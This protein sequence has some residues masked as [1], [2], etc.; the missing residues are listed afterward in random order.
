MRNLVLLAAMGLPVLAA[1]LGA[2]AQTFVPFVIP[3]TQNPGSLIAF[4]SK[5]IAVDS[6]RLVA[7]DGHFFAGGERVRIWG[8]NL[9]FAANFPAHADA[10]RLA[11]RL[12]A[13]GI[14]SVRH[15]HMDGTVFPGGVWDPKDERKLSAEA[16][17]RLDYLMDQLARH[18][19]YSNLNLH[20]S[21]A[22]ARVLKLPDTASIDSFDKMVDLFTPELIDAQKQYARDMLTHVNPYRKSA[23][24]P[25]GVRRADDPA[26]AFVEINNEDSLFM[27]GW[28][29][30]LR[31]LPD[32]YGRLLQ[33]RYNEWLAKRY[34]ADANL[35]KAWSAG[36][37]P[38]GENLLAGASALSEKD[39][40][41]TWRLELH[42][43]CKGSAAPSPGDA[44]AVRIEIAQTD[45]VSWH[46]QF[47]QFGVAL[48]AGQYYTL[49]FRA[50]ADKP[51]EMSLGVGQHEGPW[52]NLG[53]SQNVKLA[54]EWKSFRI[55]FV[56]K[57][58]EKNARVG[59]SLGA[60]A[61]PVELADV[62]LRPGGKEGLAKGESL[63]RV[64]GV[65]PARGEGILPS[66]VVSSSSSSSAATASPASLKGKG[67]REETEARG[68][69]AR[70]TRGQALGAPNGDVRDTPV[71][72]FGPG[73]TDARTIDR[74]RFLA[75]TEKAYFDSMREYVK[76]DLGCQAA[77]TGTIV[78]GPLGLWAQSDMDYIDGHAYWHH[79]NFP[80]RPWD[81]ADWTVEQEAMVDH[82]ENSTLYH[83]AAQR[84]AGKPYT[85]S[86]YNH[87]APNDYQAECVPEIASF[88]AAQDWDGIWL[89]AYSHAAGLDREAFSSFFDIDANP[90]KWGFVPAGAA[91]FRYE[92]EN[93]QMDG[94]RVVPLT[95]A[96]DTLAGLAS[97]HLRGG[98]EMREIGK[99]A[100]ESNR[101]PQ[102]VYLTLGGKMENIPSHRYED[103]IWDW[104]PVKGD[105]PNRILFITDEFV[106]VWLG[107]LAESAGGKVDR[108]VLDV[109]TPTFAV[110][111]V[112]PVDRKL[113]S[114]SNRVLVTACGRCENTGMVFT[115]DRRS[116]GRNWGKPPVRIE[117]VDG[118]V[119]VPCVT[120]GAWSCHALNP[121]GTA[122]EE[123]PINRPSERGER[124]AY[125]TITL[126]AKY[127]TMWYL[128]E[129]K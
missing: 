79:P 45:D 21:R 12:A 97:A 63:S 3:A 25:S 20:V 124:S 95:S 53:L 29:D 94:R 9:C 22:W 117:P 128:L 23:G 54:A 42:P 27:W 15:H 65:S 24:S 52:A 13:F 43:P 38:L 85:V 33:D 34:G 59:F 82:P 96:P 116:V 5:P 120:E 39:V 55:G 75:E 10:E 93:R 81:A 91:I 106:D 113:M 28:E 109:R 125:P 35:A 16:I 118:K 64:A 70:G 18:G 92:D 87:P 114:E 46:I 72:L 115:A 8:V 111:T 86:E 105:S 11:A 102:R 69:D 47:R 98:S 88:A 30:K 121:D 73:D 37:E 112:T 108:S 32:F 90:A 40:P 100:F 84:L 67:S 51:R 19:I 80:H 68:R 127:A 66:I 77:V 31:R 110:I 1:C 26:V 71:Q 122:G 119:A 104:L 123:V 83:L 62:E 2:R 61:V 76:K 60:S 44:N 57:A 49:S 17:D 129:R 56:A 74:M 36:A 6:P 58:D 48:R 99:V 78:F 103:R 4:E 50:R 89:F 107:H 7:K 101:V 126:S 14:N 41:K